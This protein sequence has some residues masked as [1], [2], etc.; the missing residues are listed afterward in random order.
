MVEKLKVAELE[1]ALVIVPPPGWIDFEARIEDPL[2][3]TTVPVG[4][5][6]IL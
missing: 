6:P 3:R 1:V 2:K 4:V 5:G